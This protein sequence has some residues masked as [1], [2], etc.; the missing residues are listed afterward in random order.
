M[1]KALVELKSIS[2]YSQSRFHQTEKLPKELHDAFEKRTWRERCNYLSDGRIYIPQMAF[3]NCLS[4]VAKYLGEKIPGKKN[5]TWTKHFESGIQIE[6]DLILDVKKDDIEG[7]WFH[8]PSDGK[9]GGSTRVLK[10]FPVIREWKGFLTF[11]IIDDLITEEV[12]HRYLNEAGRF[13]GIGRFRPQ[14]RGFYGRFKVEG[15]VWE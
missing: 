8:V 1:K 7:E 5:A 14:R 2:P 12:F 9:P 6:D 10:C 11:Y 3:K 13:I 15:I 4:D